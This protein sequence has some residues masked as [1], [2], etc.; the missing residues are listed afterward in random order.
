MF[1][2]I[3]I[4]T[5][6]QDVFLQSNHFKIRKDLNFPS[7]KSIAFEAGAKT[8]IKN[9]ILETGGG[10][11]NSAV[12]FARLGLRTASCF[13][14]GHDKRGQDITKQLKKEGV[15]KKFIQKSVDEDTSLSI[16]FLA[17]GGERNIFVYRGAL[18]KEDFLHLSKLKT[19]W[20]YVSSVGGNIKLLEKVAQFA[21][22]KNI[23]LALNPGSEEL[24]L[25][26]KKLLKI[27]NQTDILI[28]NRNEAS[29][30]M[31]IS[32]NFQKTIFRKACGITPGIEV[33][34]DGKDGAYVAEENRGYRIGIYDWPLIDRLGAG[35]AFGSGF[36]GGYIK[37]GSIEKA[38]QY[39]AA[40][41]SSVVGKIGAKEGIIKEFP[42]KPLPVKIVT[43]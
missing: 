25:G 21:K 2:V 42:A 31:N 27:F 13:R 20:F 1:D 9:L 38:L 23:H 7:G 41:A 17:M 16:V 14:V 30:L 24:N 4:G 36:V 18:L 28:L 8:E 35:D 43:F 6:T 5:A 10:A 29:K 22:R 19:K 26:R 11:T 39:A 33:I 12:T 3:T 40:N 34:T 32:Y 15:S 37:Y